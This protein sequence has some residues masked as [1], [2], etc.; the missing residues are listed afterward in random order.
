MMRTLDASR[1]QILW[2]VEAPT[3]LPFAFSG[4]R[5]AIT[6]APIGAIFGEWV[7]ADSGLGHLI[8]QDN[9]QFETARLFAAVVVLAAI[10]ISLFALVA[11]AERRVVTW[12]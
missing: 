7:G 11:L 6:F 8:L 1:A 12:R 2:R 5:I 4:T 9:A 10:A 3:A